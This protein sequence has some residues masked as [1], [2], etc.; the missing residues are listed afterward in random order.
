MKI[1]SGTANRPESP[2]LPSLRTLSRLLECLSLCLS[3]VAPPQGTS[4]AHTARHL[5]GPRR[6]DCGPAW[7]PTHRRHREALQRRGGLGPNHGKCPRGDARGPEIR[8]TQPPAPCADRKSLG[9]PSDADVC[10][11]ADVFI[12][13]PTCT[14]VNDNLMELLLTI[15]ALKRASV[16]RVIAV[17]PYYGYARQDRKDR[18]RVPISAADVARMFEAMGVPSICSASIPCVDPP[19]RR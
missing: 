4:G 2:C 10:Y 8:P 9:P 19:L 6:G 11:Q 15:S 14:P 16:N 1:I 17:V 7:G 13:Q 12:V 3:P 5:Q 18:S